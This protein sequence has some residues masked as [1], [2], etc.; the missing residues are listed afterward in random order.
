VT[1]GDDGG[2]LEDLLALADQLVD[3]AAANRRQWVELRQA[4]GGEPGAPGAPG[5]PGGPP[6][7]DGPGDP[8]A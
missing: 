3:E 2:A 8:A 1:V 4:L 6:A 5:A 7:G